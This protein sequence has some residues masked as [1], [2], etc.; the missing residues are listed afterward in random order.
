MKV[1]KETTSDVH[2]RYPVPGSEKQNKNKYRVPVRITALRR[3]NAAAATDKPY[4]RQRQG[5][6]TPERS[7]A[8]GADLGFKG[9]GKSRHRI[10]H[11][12]I[13][14]M[15]RS[16]ADSARSLALLASNLLMAVAGEARGPTHK[17]R[18]EGRLVPAKSRVLALRFLSAAP[19]RARSR[20]G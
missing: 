2:T 17:R 3:W 8:S 12:V 18:V 15:L 13:P 5:P 10:K 20:L 14:V 11:Q 6:T 19:S 9:P 7:A 16:D 4:S 1:L